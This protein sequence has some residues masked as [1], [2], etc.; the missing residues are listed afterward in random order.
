MYKKYP[1]SII[2]I[3]YEDPLPDIAVRQAKKIIRILDGCNNYFIYKHASISLIVN[4]PTNENPKEYTV[5]PSK[6]HNN[7]NIITSSGYTPKDIIETVIYRH[8]DEVKQYNEAYGIKLSLLPIHIIA[9][10]YPGAE[11]YVDKQLFLEYQ[12]HL[13][14]RSFTLSYNCNDS[15]MYEGGIDYL[16]NF[17]NEQISHIITDSIADKVDSIKD[18]I[19]IKPQPFFIL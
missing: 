9:I 10:Q 18:A 19:I 11:Q 1:F 13:I 5:V 15:K 4:V 8:H 17:L 6:G 16:E 14:V 7:I 2:I 3:Y 12:T